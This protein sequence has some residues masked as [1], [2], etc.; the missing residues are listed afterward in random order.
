MKVMKLALSEGQVH[1]RLRQ[2]MVEDIWYVHEGF[3]L[4]QNSKLTLVTR[5]QAAYDRPRESLELIRRWLNGE[6]L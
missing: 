4:A 5:L 2:Y 1:V 3:D 6:E